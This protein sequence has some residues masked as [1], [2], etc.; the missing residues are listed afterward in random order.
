MLRVFILLFGIIIISILF[1]FPPFCIHYPNGVKRE[2]SYNFI[3][4]PPSEYH[5]IDHD[6][7]LTEIITASTIIFLSLLLVK[8]IEDTCISKRIHK[9]NICWR[10][11]AS[12]AARTALKYSKYAAYFG[13]AIVIKIYIQKHIV[14]PLYVAIS[15]PLLLASGVF[16][17]VF[18]VNM[19]FVGVFL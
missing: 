16:I 14:L 15:I 8:T 4:S 18:V 10:E 11:R 1:I 3:L 12:G 6:L 9:G 19:I 13:V 7:L 5:A 2:Q 17:L